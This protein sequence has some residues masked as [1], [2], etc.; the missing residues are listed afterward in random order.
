MV[1]SGTESD[2]EYR[3][4]PGINDDCL[5]SERVSILR[6]LSFVRQGAIYK[7]NPSVWFH[8]E[9]V[10]SIGLVCGSIV[11]ADI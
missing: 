5:D 9:V 10:A 1:S 7:D 11:V 6:L 8:V 3:A 4:W 2:V